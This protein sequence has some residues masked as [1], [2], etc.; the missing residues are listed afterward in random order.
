M[1]TADELDEI[2]VALSKSCE[3]KE[4]EN[5]RQRARE[6]EV[7]GKGQRCGM[8]KGGGYIIRQEV[9]SALLPVQ[10]ERQQLTLETLKD[11]FV[12]VLLD[13][14]LLCSQLHWE[15]RP[16]PTSYALPSSLN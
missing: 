5:R 2:S 4:S 6:S 1:D 7:K 15:L 16:I 14:A 10:S 12:G 3:N 8:R 9:C 13:T 11:C